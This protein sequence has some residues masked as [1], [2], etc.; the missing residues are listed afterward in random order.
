[1]YQ[2]MD[3]YQPRKRIVLGGGNMK[4]IP[5]WNNKN[6]QCYFC[7]ET[8]SVKYAMKIKTHPDKEVCVCSK[9]VLIHN[10][11]AVKE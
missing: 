5:D 10:D 1:M 7:G 8:R 11:K 3:E 9:C 4:F 6:L 2:K